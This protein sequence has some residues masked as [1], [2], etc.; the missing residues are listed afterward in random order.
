MFGDERVPWNP[1]KGFLRGGFIFLMVAMVLAFL[2]WLIG[3]AKDTGPFTA[4]LQFG[5][6]AWFAVNAVERVANR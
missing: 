3:D 6:P 4:V 5:I 1:L 2:I